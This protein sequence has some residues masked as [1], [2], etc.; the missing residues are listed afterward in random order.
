MV[1]IEFLV[2]LIVHVFLILVKPGRLKVR[3]E[4]LFLIFERSAETLDDMDA[5]NGCFHKLM[6]FFCWLLLEVDVIYAIYDGRQ[7]FGEG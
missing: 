4:V 3:I 1:R 5:N 6:S 7:F 2:F